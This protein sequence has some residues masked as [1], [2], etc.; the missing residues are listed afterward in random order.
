[1]ARNKNKDP[2]KVA[3]DKISDDINHISTR[4]EHAI[5]VFRSTVNQLVSINSEMEEKM[6]ELDTLSDFIQ[7]QKDIASKVVSDNENVRAKILE[8]IGE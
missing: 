3:V 2:I 4:K 1:M 7:H 5:S 8:I 6:S